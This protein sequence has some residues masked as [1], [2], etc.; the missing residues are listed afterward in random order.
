MSK[1]ISSD[2]D[3]MSGVPVIK[4]SRIPISRIV[5]LLSEG[6]TIDSIQTMYPHL[7]KGLL[8]G[9]INEL[10]QDIDKSLYEKA[11]SV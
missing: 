8:Q 6:H 11:P 7:K 4:G 10:I 1:Y 9:A 3:I 2:P 5:F